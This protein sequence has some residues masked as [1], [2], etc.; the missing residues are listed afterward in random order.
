MMGWFE[1]S[2][3]LRFI[4]VYKINASRYS[5]SYLFD[6]IYFIFFLISNYK[7]I[8]FIFISSR[9]IRASQM[10]NLNKFYRDIQLRSEKFLNKDKNDRENYKLSFLH[11]C[12]FGP[13]YSPI[14]HVVMKMKPL[15]RTI[16]RV[17]ALLT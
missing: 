16:S 1:T 2:Y 10:L 3:Y 12:L 9:I 14:E 8:T 7:S 15:L 13:K 4:I 6:K 17:L 11:L 5:F